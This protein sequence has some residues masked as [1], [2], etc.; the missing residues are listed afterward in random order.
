MIEEHIRGRG[1]TDRTVLE[2]LS[3]VPRRVFV[4]DAYKEHACEDTALPLDY[5]QSISQ[6]YIVAFMTEQ[7]K[8]KPTHR[9]L[10]IGTGS[11][12]QTAVLAHL[13]QEVY[14]VERIPQLGERAKRVL[15]LLGYDNIHYRIGNGYDGWPEY[16]P[17]DG[18][19]VTAAP[20]HIPPAL[21]EQLSID[22]RLVIPVGSQDDQTI[23]T[24]VKTAQGWETTR[25]IRVRFVP[26]VPDPDAAD[27]LI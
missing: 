2:A 9:I 20:R 5:D 23:W 26:M 21:M 4:P 27:D 12:Y 25:T 19:L 18:I 3:R 7:L 15:N 6:P 17:Y 10:E 11:G 1:I 13:A 16:A 24:V 14:T 8:V 22:G